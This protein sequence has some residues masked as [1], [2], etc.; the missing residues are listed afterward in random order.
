MNALPQWL[1]AGLVFFAVTGVGAGAGAAGEPYPARPVTIV[2]P[3]TPGGT[4]DILARLLG[5][6]LEQRLGKPFVVENRPGAGS[7]TAAVAVARAAPDGY[8]LMMAPSSTLVINISLHKKLPYDPVA[9]FVPVA[10][11]VKTPFVLV[12]HPALPVQSVTDLIGF[13]RDRKGQLSFASVG[14]GT[15]HHLFAELFNSMTGIQ[16]THVPYKGA[17]PALTDLAGG[18]VDVMFCDIAPALPLLADGKL[19]ALGVSSKVR[20]AALP[21][22]APIAEL[23]VEGFDAVSWQMIVAPAA[24]PRDVV[25]RLHD[26][27]RQIMAQPEI[28]DH[29]VTMGMI[30][31]D[32]PSLDDLRAYVKSETIR[33]GKVVEQAGI[34]GSL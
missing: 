14:P 33:W 11:L 13:A 29:F 3:F 27:I 28:S 10:L 24:T 4:T 22:V 26:E 1:L 34:A 6:H 7:I 12:V 16:M 5:Q 25:E 21:A 30:P 9:D 15:P 20:V 19:R 2:V 32:T 18:H 23:G 31:V 8:T 17:A